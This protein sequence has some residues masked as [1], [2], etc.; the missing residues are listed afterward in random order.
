MAKVL[1]Q[2]P[3][4]DNPHPGLFDHH[5][6]LTNRKSFLTGAGVTMPL[7]KQALASKHFRECG[8]ILRTEQIAQR[9]VQYSVFAT[10]ALPKTQNNSTLWEFYR[11]FLAGRN[12]DAMFVNQSVQLME[13]VT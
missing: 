13:N 6:V 8:C 1:L 3:A 9:G 2:A 10:P 5:P 11:R 7:I 4:I 12:C